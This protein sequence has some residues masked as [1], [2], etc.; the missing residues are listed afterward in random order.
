MTMNKSSL[1]LFLCVANSAR[2]Q[3]AEGLARRLIRRPVASA[4]SRPTVLSPYAIEV[5]SE[6]G[7]DLGAQRSKSVHEIDPSVVGTVITLCAEQVCPAFLGN[8]ERLHWPIFSRCEDQAEVDR[9]WDALLAAGATPLQ[10][11][12]IRD[13]FGLSFQIV[14]RRFM[15]LMSDPNPAKSQAVL[16]AMMKMVKFD[17]AEL[18][19]AHAEAR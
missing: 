17:V 7:I 11:G 10:C 9:Y 6:L 3:M 16:A 19:R 15:E 5:M 1:V 14:P 2:S 18:E 4:G 8:A 12:W 13:R